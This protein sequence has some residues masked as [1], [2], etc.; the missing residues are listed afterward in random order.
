MIAAPRG[1]AHEERGD[2]VPVPDECYAD[3]H[4]FW[5]AATLEEVREHAHVLSA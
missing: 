4:G 5:K 2:E 1:L 3:A